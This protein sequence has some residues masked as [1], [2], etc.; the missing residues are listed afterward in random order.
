M[1]KIVKIWYH[2]PGGFA[3]K[4]SKFVDYLCTGG[5]SRRCGSQQALYSSILSAYTKYVRMIGKDDKI[6]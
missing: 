5:L 3:R 1:E 4:K 6:L 2:S